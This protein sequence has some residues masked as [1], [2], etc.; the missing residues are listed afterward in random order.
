MK[1]ITIR[2]KDDLDFENTSNPEDIDYVREIAK[3]SKR[4]KDE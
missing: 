2:V 3:V 4:F 1:T